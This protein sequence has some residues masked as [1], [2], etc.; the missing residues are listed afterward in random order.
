MDDRL[1]LWSGNDS[2][3]ERYEVV[4]NSGPF[5]YTTDGP[6]SHEKN[7]LDITVFIKDGKLE[8][9]LY[10]NPV[11]KSDFY[12]NY[13]SAHPI[14]TLNSIP[15]SLALRV[16]RNCSDES[17]QAEY[18]NELNRALVTNSFYPKEIVDSAF[19]RARSKNRS[20]LLVPRDKENEKEQ[21]RTVLSTPYHPSLHSL[22]K[23]LREALVPLK[24]L[25][26]TFDK[27]TR[28]PPIV[29]WNR[30]VT[31]KQLISPSKVNLGASRRH[32]VMVLINVIVLVVQHV[33]MSFRV[34][35]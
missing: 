35:L 22:P 4:C 11:S 8:T 29:A 13:H 12:L 21:G 18:L 5:E 3:Y 23:I 2:H 28:P 1:Q 7:F 26:H 27:I 17:F 20:D 10:R 31:L 32:A 9:K 16:R 24:G 6:P 25:D 19:E 15:Y 14:A 33:K 30:G 34:I